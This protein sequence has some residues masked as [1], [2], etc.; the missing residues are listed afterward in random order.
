MPE[1]K[2]R[3]FKNININVWISAA[4]ITAIVSIVVLAL[5]LP[6]GGDSIPTKTDMEMV[7]VPAGEFL[8]GDEDLDRNMR[9]QHA[10]YLDAYWIDQ[11]EV[12]NAHYLACIQDSACRGIEPSH[13]VYDDSKSDHPVV[14]V[15]WQDAV[16]FCE[17]AGKTLPTEAQWEKAARG[18]DGRL[19][20]WGN[21]PP[22]PRLANY[23]QE[24]DGTVPVGSYPLGAIPYG[25]LDMAGNVYEWTQDWYEWDYYKNS[26]YKNPR[27][28]ETGKYHVKRGAA[29][30]S[31]VDFILR[32]GFRKYTGSLQGYH[33]GFRCVFEVE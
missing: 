19:Y 13:Y 11:T 26:P 6:S 29:W 1:K 33:L 30:G 7:F 4:L 5:P 31:F 3:P 21:N 9:P 17:W 18:T 22:A 23:E 24:A 32:T 20:P 15:T 16:D 2:K 10:V 28:P 12:T 8:M 25:A 27:G 14:Y